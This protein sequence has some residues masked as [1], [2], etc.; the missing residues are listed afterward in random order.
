MLIRL[1]HDSGESITDIELPAVPRVNEAIQ[2]EGRRRAYVQRV[3]WLPPPS[4][5]EPVV[6]LTVMVLPEH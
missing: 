6:I 5:I 3:L 1:E 2:L 4:D